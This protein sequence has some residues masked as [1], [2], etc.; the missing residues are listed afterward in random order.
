MNALD[1]AVD[2]QRKRRIL[3]EMDQNGGLLTIVP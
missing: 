2:S 1:A 3:R